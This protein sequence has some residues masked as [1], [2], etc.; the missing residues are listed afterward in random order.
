MASENVMKVR[1]LEEKYKV[2]DVK[3]YLHVRQAISI[4]SIHEH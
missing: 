4:L 3:V 1:I 2:E